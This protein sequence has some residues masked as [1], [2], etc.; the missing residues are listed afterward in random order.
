MHCEAHKISLGISYLKSISIH[1]DMEYVIQ[2]RM[3]F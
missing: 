3:D 2:V 1:L